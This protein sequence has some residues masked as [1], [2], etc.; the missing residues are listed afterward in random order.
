MKALFLFLTLMGAMALKAQLNNERTHA[1]QKF[2]YYFSLYEDSEDVNCNDLTFYHWYDNKD[3]G[4]NQGG[5]QGKL[6]HGEYKAVDRD[7][8]L[9]HE[10]EFKKGLKHGTWRHWDEQ[11]RLISIKEYKLGLLHG[12]STFFRSDSGKIQR[13]E[14]HRLGQRHGLNKEFLMN[15]EERLTTYRQGVEKLPKEKKPIKVPKIKKE[16]VKK[17]KKAKDK[18]E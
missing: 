2:S 15:G 17:E 13:I 11:G 8:H 18:E 16:K 14:R 4:S 10:G 3:I 6:L 5:F 9:I 1:D 12:K 7:N